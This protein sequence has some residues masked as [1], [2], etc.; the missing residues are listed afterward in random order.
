MKDIPIGGGLTCRD[1]RERSDA[2]VD[3]ELLIEAIVRILRHIGICDGCRELVE[4][5]VRLK[6]RVRASVRGLGVPSS[7]GTS[8]RGLIRS[9]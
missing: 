5:K 8:I 7:L 2:F 3:N 1:V 9:N 4:E 6:R